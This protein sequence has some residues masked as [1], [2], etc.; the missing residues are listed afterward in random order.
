MRQ[1]Q[2]RHAAVSE[3]LLQQILASVERLETGL[4]T[5]FAEQSERFDGKLD[6]QTARFDAKFAEQSARLD[7][8]AARLERLE[9]GLANFRADMDKMR[10]AIMDRIDR[11]QETMKALQNDILVNFGTTDAVRRAHDSTREELRALH[12]ILMITVSKV[13]RTRKPDA[14]P[15]RRKNLTAPEGYRIATAAFCRPPWRQWHG[16][17]RPLHRLHQ[18]G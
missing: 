11:L 13:R 5:R 17:C 10:G 3:H 18:R 2:R 9:L 16:P 14:R 1:V 7:A 15:D 4:D 6:E 12:E 8:H